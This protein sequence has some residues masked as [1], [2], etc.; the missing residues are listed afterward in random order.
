[1]I[2]K[3]MLFQL[4]R[5]GPLMGVYTNNLLFI[6]GLYKNRSLFLKMIEKSTKDPKITY[7]PVLLETI[8]IDAHWTCK[9]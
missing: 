1:M 2:R 3:P 5:G 4:L 6:S 9:L 7:N 8:T